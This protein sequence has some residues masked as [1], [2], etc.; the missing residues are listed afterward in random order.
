MLSLYDN[1]L[2]SLGG[3]RGAEQFGTS[4]GLTP[5]QSD[6]VLRAM[7]PAFSL[8]LKRASRDPQ[9][10]MSLLGL[11]NGFPRQ[12]SATPFAYPLDADAMKAA[13]QS[14]EV[15]FGPPNTH[16]S[17]ADQAALLTGV[18]SD[19]MLEM[20]PAMASTIM[21]GLQSQMPV[22]AG[23][24][25]DLVSAFISGFERGRP[26]PKPEPDFS[27]EAAA[28]MLNSFFTGFQRGRTEEPPEAVEAPRADEDEEPSSE[29]PVFGGLFEA[30]EQIQKSN[31]D[32][33][34]SMF[35]KLYGAKKQ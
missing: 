28:D 21:T 30:G 18:S 23:P 17:I 35:D 16:K 2:Q 33:M 19:K 27:P 4:F 8:G 6:R 11:I 1:V 7:I 12:A 26:E 14:L 15:L 10:M 24:M 3:T 29:S 32:A 5:T 34:Q 31:M 13:Q 20:M 25:A 22:Y 9:S